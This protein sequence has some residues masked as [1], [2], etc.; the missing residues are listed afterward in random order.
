MRNPPTV[1]VPSIVPPVLLIVVRILVMTLG[2]LVRLVSG[3]L[4]GWL[5][6]LS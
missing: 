1:L 2:L 4:V 3:A 5:P 6:R